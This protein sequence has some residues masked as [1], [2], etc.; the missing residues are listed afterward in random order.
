MPE[1][2]H[3]ISLKK[4]QEDGQSSASV[5]QSLMPRKKPFASV[6]V[7]GNKESNSGSHYR[8]LMLARQESKDHDQSHY[9]SLNA[10]VTSIL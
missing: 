9:Q 8:P 1:T 6:D 7:N 4:V 5:N 3:Y 2:S 10:A